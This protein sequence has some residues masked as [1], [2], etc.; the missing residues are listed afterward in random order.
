VIDV[1]KYIY[2]YVFTKEEGDLYS[3]S[4]PDI[5]S[6]Y[7]SGE[8]LQ[9]ALE[10]AHDVLCLTLYKLEEAGKPIPP[11]SDIKAIKSEQNSFVSLMLCDT[12]E[13]RKFFDNKAVKKTLT[14]P[15]W[16]NTMSEKRGL[17][18]SSVLQNALKQ[19]LN[20]QDTNL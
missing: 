4:F 17:N 19:E 8:G 20:I 2:P 1:A 13:Y 3:V 11:A 12:I 6:C 15:S 16:L 18:F 10:V 7:T 5:E 9:N 14:I